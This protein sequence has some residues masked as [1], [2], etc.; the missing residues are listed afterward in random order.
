MNIIN[1]S[2]KNAVLNFS[3]QQVTIV[4]HCN[5]LS[6]HEVTGSNKWQKLHTGDVLLVFK[7]DATYTFQKQNTC[8]QFA[9]DIFD[10]ESLLFVI[11]TTIDSTLQPSLCMICR[12]ISNAQFGHGK[13]ATCQ[14]VC[15]LIIIENCFVPT[16][17]FSN[18][19]C[20]KAR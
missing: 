2:D 19:F 1:K 16:L 5:W 7:E 12:V 15:K 13:F 6:Y 17:H 18:P 10:Y 9:N 4:L 14:I 20:S 3:D 8:F 11:L